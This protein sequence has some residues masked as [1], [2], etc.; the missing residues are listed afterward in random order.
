MS[1]RFAILLRVMPISR[2]G[3]CFCHTVVSQAEEQIRHVSKSLILLES[4]EDLAQ[5]LG[6]DNIAEKCSCNNRLTMVLS[7]L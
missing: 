5:V 1:Q 2:H 3:H 6:L 7:V 4:A